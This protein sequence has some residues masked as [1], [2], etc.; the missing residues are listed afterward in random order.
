MLKNEIVALRSGPSGIKSKMT[1]IRSRPFS[2]KRP[3]TC[4]SICTDG[5][6]ARG[7]SI[8]KA[9][10]LLPSSIDYGGLTQH[11]FIQDRRCFINSVEANGVAPLSQHVSD[12]RAKPLL[13]SVERGCKYDR[14][15]RIEASNR[16]ASVL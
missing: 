4:V 13:S 6:H 8:L 1:D 2:A 7:R 14:T 9:V 5:I 10:K 16:I 11:T 3:P 12:D 15:A